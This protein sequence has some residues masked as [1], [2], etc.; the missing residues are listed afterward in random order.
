MSDSRHQE[1]ARRAALGDVEAAEALAR[2]QER[3]GERA[4]AIGPGR[5]TGDAVATYILAGRA[6]FTLHDPETGNRLTYR[7]DRASAEKW[8]GAIPP[9]GLPYFVKALTG[10]DA[11]VYS[12]WSYLGLL[13][14]RDPIAVPTGQLSGLEWPSR[15]TGLHATSFGWL[16]RHLGGSLGAVEVWHT[17]RCGRCHRK[18]TVPESIAAG[19]GPECRT[20]MEE[21][22]PRGQRGAPEESARRVKPAAEPLGYARVLGPAPEPAPAWPC[23]CTKMPDD[24]GACPYCTRPGVGGTR[25]FDRAAADRAADL[26][27]APAEPEDEETA[28]WLHMMGGTRP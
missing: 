28:A 7:V 17:G 21:V 19:I 14:G 26:A 4:L 12:H 20:K 22:G 24:C 6:E 2:A 9:T 15:A 1:L 16:V 27:P 11:E 3:T 18:L 13:H 25:R 10:P 5:L 8:R 23:G